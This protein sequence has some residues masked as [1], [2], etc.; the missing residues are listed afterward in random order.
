MSQI[1]ID[2]KSYIPTGDMLKSVYDSDN[3]GVVDS[4]ENSLQLEGHSASYFE[5][6]KAYQN[7]ELQESDTLL[8]STSTDQNVLSLTVTKTGTYL[9]LIYAE[10]EPAST[11]YFGGAKA[12]LGTTVI[13]KVSHRPY[14]TT[15]ND[16]AFSMSK[17]MNLSEND[18]LNLNIT[19]STTTYTKYRRCRI[20]IK[21]V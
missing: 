16:Y 14:G 17:I 11:S 21:E 20:T 19:S 1:L 3:D 9:V 12:L 13:G 5:V 4:S 10:Y 7:T 2:S 8:T 6:A 18:V 15:A